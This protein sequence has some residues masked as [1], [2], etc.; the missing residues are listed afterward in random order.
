VS[1]NTAR[2]GD[3]SLH[4]EPILV[5]SFPFRYRDREE[6]GIVKKIARSAAVLLLVC[7]SMSA[8]AAEP[9][10]AG[11]SAKETKARRLLELMRA[12][13]MAMQSVDAMIGAMQS[14]MGQSEEFWTEF[15]AQI[16]P[17][18]LLELLVPVYAENLEES[19]LDGLIAFYESPVGKRYVEK[20]GLILQQSMLAG[21]KWG[22]QLAMRAIEKMQE[23]KDPSGE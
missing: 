21:Q 16:K 7:F 8:V 5:R 9:A 3:E 10:A 4:V 20:Q 19:D 13:D 15:R 6:E 17:D 23:R 18:E 22:E 11:K 14:S 12:A 2:E 1:G